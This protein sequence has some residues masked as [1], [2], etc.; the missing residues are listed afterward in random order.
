MDCLNLGRITNNYTQRHNNLRI[1]YPVVGLKLSNEPKISKTLCMYAQGFMPFYITTPE[2]SFF[3]DR[4][5]A[6]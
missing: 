3:L 1:R 4:L 5:G 2:R 6:A